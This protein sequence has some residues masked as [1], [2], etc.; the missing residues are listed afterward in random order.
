MQRDDEGQSL[1]RSYLLGE[2]DPEPQ[3][4]LEQRLLADDEYFEALLIAE[5]EIIDQYLSGSLTSLEQ[6][7]FA[8]IF[9]STP[10]RRQKLNFARA[11]RKYI[12]LN[13]PAGTISSDASEQ[14]PSFWKRFLPSFL[15]ARHPA[16]SFSLATALLL[17]LVGVTWVAVKNLRQQNNP[18][19]ENPDNVLA[20]TLTPG[21]L[22]GTGTLERV[23][24]PARVETVRLQLKLP[25]DEYKTYSATV[26]VVGGQEI[27]TADNLKAETTGDGLAVQVSI[28]AAKLTSEDYQLNLSGLNTNGQPEKV[29]TYDFRVLKNPPNK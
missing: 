7:K 29:S 22:R 11:L 24:I 21:A 28:P 20:I 16:L 8:S 10:E 17:V 23:V 6:E 18:G 15:R 13:E 4:Q 3:Q 19:Q 26:K 12:Q 9:L 25:S 2:L 1:L 5:D 27:F 14:S